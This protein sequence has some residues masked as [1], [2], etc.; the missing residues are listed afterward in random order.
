MKDE[1]RLS[2]PPYIATTIYIQLSICLSHFLLTCRAHLRKV[3]DAARLLARLQGT[4]GLPDRR[5]FLQ[6]QVGSG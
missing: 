2:Q 3:K 4:Q 6:L 1:A 5:D